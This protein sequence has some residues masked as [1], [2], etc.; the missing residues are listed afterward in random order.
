MLEDIISNLI[1]WNSQMHPSDATI[2]LHLMSTTGSH[3]YIIPVTLEASQNEKD[4]N[5]Y[6]SVK[7]PAQ[8]VQFI[9]DNV[10]VI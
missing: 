4:S 8:R 2:R 5:Y 1:R 6:K 9:D 10:R 3:I 7:G